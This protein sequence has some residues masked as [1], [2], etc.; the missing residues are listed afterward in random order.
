[1]R[2]FQSIY[3]KVTLLVI[4]TQITIMSVIGAIYYNSFSAQVDGSLR[5]RIEIPARLLESSRGRLVSLNSSEAVRVQVGESVADVLVVN[6]SKNVVFSL[7]PEFN[8]RN[9]QSISSIDAAWFDFTNPQTRIEEIDE[10]EEPFL[11]SLTPIRGVVD[12]EPSMFV[13]TKVSTSEAR[14]EKQRIAGLIVAGTIITAVITSVIL[15]LLF[16]FQV[17]KRL[18][19]VANVLNAVT[20]GNLQARIPNP[21]SKDEIGVLQRQLNSMVERRGHAEHTISELNTNLRTLNAELEQRVIERTQQLEI[22]AE[23]AE[24]ANQVKSQFLAAMSHELRTPLNAVI[25]LSQFVANG[26]MGDVNAEQADA[27]NLVVSSGQHLLGLINDVLDIS[28]IEAGAFKLFIEPEIDLNNALKTVVA[29]AET[30]TKDKPVTIIKEIDQNL[31]SIIGDRQRITQ[32]MLNLVSNAV[33]FTEQGSITIHAHVQGDNILLGVE[34]TGPGIPAEDHEIVFESFRQTET[35]LKVGSGTGLGL[36]ISKRLA[37]AHG[38]ELWLESEPG[39]GVH[40]QV[41][42]PIRSELLQKEIR[43]PEGQH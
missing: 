14:A 13:Y 43:V 31:P 10:G 8:G 22:A 26:V 33:K 29:T 5:E 17:F 6:S 11:V 34:D 9:I 40:F 4:V 30:L 3:V 37:E 18:G 28:K 36:P 42:L 23:A 20:E 7:R 41:L 27:L 15:F 1:M 35:G 24:R 32:I 25:N 19:A 2:W 39:N 16:Y 21:N 12:D 38:G